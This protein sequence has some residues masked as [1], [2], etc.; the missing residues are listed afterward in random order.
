M[1]ADFQKLKLRSSNLS[2]VHEFD[3][4]STLTK[5]NVKLLEKQ[6]MLQKYMDDT[7]LSTGN[8]EEDRFFDEDYGDDFDDDADGEGNNGFDFDAQIKQQIESQGQK[9]QHVK[10]QEQEWPQSRQRKSALRSS[11]ATPIGS[12][13]YTLVDKPTVEHG[14]ISSFSSRT[15]SSVQSQYSESDTENS[16]YAADYDDFEEVGKTLNLQEKFRRKQ[17]EAKQHV[18][19]ERLL[20][21][22]QNTNSRS[23]L[24]RS[25]SRLAQHYDIDDITN[26]ADFED[27][28]YID[29]SKIYRFKANPSPSSHGYLDRKKSL[30]VMRVVTSVAGSPKKVKKYLS[31]V[32]MNS[33]LDKYPKQSYPVYDRHGNNNHERELDE[34]DDLDDFDLTITL[35]DYK[36]LKRKSKKIDFSQYVET[37]SQHQYRQHRESR[38]SRY[39]PQRLSSSGDYSSKNVLFSTPEDSKTARLTK[40]GKIKLIRS[41][42]KPMVRKVMPAHIYGEIVY[43]PQLKKWCGNEEDLA[44]FETLN[45]SKPQ[46]ITKKQSMPQMIGNMVYDD[47]KLRWVSVTG[48]Y[49]DDPFGED[50]DTIMNGSEEPERTKP[51]ILKQSGRGVSGKLVPSESSMSLA[52]HLKKKDSYFKVTPEMYKTWKTEEGRWVRK[53]GNWFPYDENTHKF[54]YE[55]KTFLNQQ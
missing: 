28:N 8:F 20:R 5:E 54:K 48:N 31:S 40:E 19:E 15:P 42:G 37:P 1:E 46:L 30:P 24:P 35:S 18:E 7:G 45:Y 3:E 49:E 32:D 21:R 10:Q 52:D 26:D 13:V 22:K 23:K 6:K 34:L 41:L 16:D 27:L 25:D 47:K 43:D 53:V 29:P 14:S 11:M 50:F 2:T 55:L 9:K 12:H 17:Q 44:R 36:K 33:K 38:D 39:I 4:R 51:G